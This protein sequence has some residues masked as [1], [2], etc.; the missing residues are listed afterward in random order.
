MPNH[1]IKKKKT[2]PSNITI[3]EKHSQILDNIH[4]VET[5][6]IP[7]LEAE[8]AELRSHLGQLTD[9]D[10]IDVRMEIQDR[11]RDIGVKLKTMRALKNKYLLDNVPYIFNYFEEKKKI[12]TGENSTKNVLH[13]FFKVKQT[14]EEASAALGQASR[15]KYHNYFGI[16]EAK[17][18]LVFFLF[19]QCTNL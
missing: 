15:Q 17:L 18:L 19:F 12:S 16:L 10:D 13:S 9:D 8:R 6:Q 2:A 11:I 1:S 4:S 7:Q 3:D 5:T 14:P